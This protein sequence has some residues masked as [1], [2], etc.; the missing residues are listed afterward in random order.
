[1]KADRILRDVA[2]LAAR[3]TLGGSIAAHGAQKYFGAFGGPGLEGAGK[4][5]ETL[6]FADG[7]SM[8]RTASLVE[9]S[10][11]ALIA[12]GV[13]GPVGPAL[14][15]STM[16]VAAQTVHRPKGYF[17]AKGGFELNAMYTLSALLL[18]NNGYGDLSVD[19]VLG[20]EKRTGPLIGWLALSGGIAGAL[21]I[22]SQ[23]TPPKPQEQTIKVER[24]ST[25]P[26]TA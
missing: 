16:I 1:M 17:A 21:F 20:L 9:M 7:K 22:L 11:G 14:L 23:R 3:L 4:Y 5:F 13:L 26:A 6:G 25:E 18:A 15:T 12:L 24:G 10:S 19:R 2:H 8:A